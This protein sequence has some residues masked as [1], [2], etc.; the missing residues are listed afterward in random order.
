VRLDRPLDEA[1]RALLATLKDRQIEFLR[2]RLVSDRARAEWEANLAAGVRELLATPVGRLAEAPA[3]GRAIDALLAPA[4]VERGLVPALE[5]A[6]LLAAARLREDA[7]AIGELVPDAARASIDR[8]LEQRGLLSERLVREAL[9]NEAVEEVMRDVLYDTLREFSD[10][11]NPFFAEWGLPSLLR[12]LSPFGLGAMSKA[13]EGLRGDFDKRLEPEIRK[14][15]QGFTRRALRDLVSFTLAKQDEPK[16]VALRK[17]LARFALDQKVSDA[18]AEAGSDREVAL[19]DTVRAALAHALTLPRT[20][21]ELRAVVELAIRAHEQQTLGEALAVYGIT[22]TP[23]VAA[24]ADATWPAVSALLAS[25][26]ARA[27]VATLVEEFFAGVTAPPEGP[28][29]AA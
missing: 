1:T 2:A 4:S 20:R 5:A 10:K 18:V 3:I 23:D 22:A 12:K 21:D 29:A 8:L 7:R 14:F 6:W 25:E 16:F 17:E 11:V 19:R 28:T 13:L 26:P 27:Y 15:L 24:L 9:Q